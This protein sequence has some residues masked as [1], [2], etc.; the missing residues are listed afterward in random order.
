MN[1]P[2][3][4]FPLPDHQP[5][6]LTEIQCPETERIKTMTDFSM[7]VYHVYKRIL[8]VINKFYILMYLMLIFVCCELPMET[9]FAGLDKVVTC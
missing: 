5:D 7:Y 9:T 1:I 4:F 3:P 2:N 8:L 6:Y